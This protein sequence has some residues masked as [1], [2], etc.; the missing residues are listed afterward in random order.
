MKI[1]AI[2]CEYHSKTMRGFRGGPKYISIGGTYNCKAATNRW[3]ANQ[4]DVRPWIYVIG[5]EQCVTLIFKTC[6][7]A[8][9]ST[10]SPQSTNSVTLRKS[11]LRPYI[12]FAQQG[13]QC[14]KSDA[15]KR[16]MEFLGRKLE[17]CRQCIYAG[18]PVEEYAEWS[19]LPKRCPEPAWI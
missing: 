17:Y 10:H 3:A 15:L 11:S 18:L 6:H 19:E 4:P 12:G 1:G 5:V 7:S 16:E 13:G 8:R 9:T 2:R 14:A